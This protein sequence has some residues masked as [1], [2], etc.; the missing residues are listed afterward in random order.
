MRQDAAEFVSVKTVGF[1]FR[2]ALADLRRC[3]LALTSLRTV[4]EAYSPANRQTAD[5]NNGNGRSRA[6]AERARKQAAWL[7]AKYFIFERLESGR[8]LWMGE[9]D[10]LPEVEAKLQNLTESNPGSNYFAFDVETGTKVKI[11]SPNDPA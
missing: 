7:M 3:I 1:S 8:L 5:N 10:D 4:K 2:M 11:K 9:A 6:F